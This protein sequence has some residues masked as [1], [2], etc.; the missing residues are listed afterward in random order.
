MFQPFPQVQGEEEYERIGKPKWDV[1]DSVH[2]GTGNPKS[3]IGIIGRT[4]KEKISA[5]S[6][7]IADFVLFDLLVYAFQ[8][9]HVT[10]CGSPHLLHAVMFFGRSHDDTVYGGNL[11]E[12][13]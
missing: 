3:R 10:F 1:D 4:R 11:R 7:E 8:I 6:F 12:G 2:Y 13:E 9:F 5:T